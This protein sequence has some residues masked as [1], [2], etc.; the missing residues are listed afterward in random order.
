M[1]CEISNTQERRLFLSWQC[2]RKKVDHYH[3]DFYTSKVD[4]FINNIS[5]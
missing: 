5:K 4:M 1:V 3:A 2:E